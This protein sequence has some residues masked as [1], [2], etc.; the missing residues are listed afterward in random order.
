MRPQAN[1]RKNSEQLGQPW[2]IFV[3]SVNIQ[4]DGNYMPHNKEQKQKSVCM[5]RNYS[6][7]ALDCVLLSFILDAENTKHSTKG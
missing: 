3:L 1:E 6:A 7:P 4:L 2:L 5:Q